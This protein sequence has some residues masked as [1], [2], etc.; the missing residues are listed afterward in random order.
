MLGRKSPRPR[1]RGRYD[2]TMTW[3]PDTVPTGFSGSTRWCTS[4][5]H[6]RN[7]TVPSMRQMGTNGVETWEDWEISCRT[8]GVCGTFIREMD[9]WNEV[10]ARENSITC[11]YNMQMRGLM[12][13]VYGF[14][15][16]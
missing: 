6:A 16:T 9:Q 2:V 10:K 4:S 15:C 11:G 5:G 3:Y 8:I 13:A 12:D 1:S 14:H 7:G